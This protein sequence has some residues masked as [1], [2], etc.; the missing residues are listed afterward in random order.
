MIEFQEM[1]KRYGRH[2][3][4]DRLTVTI[5]AGQVTALLGPNGAG[6]STALRVLLGL[7]RPS[8]GQA[9]IEDRDY[10][11]LPAPLVRVGSLLEAGAVHPGR[12]ARAHLAALARSNQL[13]ATRVEEV[14]DSV[15]LTSVAGKRA[16]SYSLGMRQRLGLAAAL[17]GDPRVLVLD[18]PFNGLDT[19]GIRWLRDLIRGL[20]AE[21]RTV[22]VSSHLMGE[23]EQIAGRVIVLAQG[24]LALDGTPAELRRVG[25][26]PVLEDAY[27]SL[28]RSAA[29][30]GAAA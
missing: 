16:G 29:E 7:A 10:R 1:T 20:A 2:T 18:E 4:V 12:T 30:S 22:L 14:I 26:S 9:L 21:G 25:G 19:A 24:R 11:D 3:A 15:G 13:P 5:P 17:L 23:V 6:K 28:I 27:M 8:S